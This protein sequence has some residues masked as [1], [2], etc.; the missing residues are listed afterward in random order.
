MA[1]MI[2]LKTSFV[3]IYQD[4]RKYADLTTSVRSLRLKI[5]NMKM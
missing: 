1:I 4:I 3:A 2:P 5:N